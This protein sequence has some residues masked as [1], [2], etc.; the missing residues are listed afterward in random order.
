MESE[1]SVSQIAAKAKELKPSIETE[2]A[3]KNAFIMP[4]ILTNQAQRSR[5]NRIAL[6]TM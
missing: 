5:Y 4:F 6:G 3:T 2:K 1:D